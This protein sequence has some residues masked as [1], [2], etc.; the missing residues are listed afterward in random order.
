MEIIK[1]SVTLEKGKKKTFKYRVSDVAEFE[2]A[3]EWVLENFNFTGRNFFLYKESEA[4]SFLKSS[5]YLE[6]YKSATY[7][8]FNFVQLNAEEYIDMILYLIKR[9][10]SQDLVIERYEQ[11]KYY[12][13][14]E[15]LF[16]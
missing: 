9:Y 15:G 13:G 8:E 4:M 10:A 5:G 2:V 3:Y 16:L 11:P 14:G 6:Y 12:F 7:S 1:I